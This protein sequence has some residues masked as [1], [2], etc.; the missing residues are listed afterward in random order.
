M[1]P[2][3][4]S[5]AKGGKHASKNH[6]QNKT[7]W[8][9]NPKTGHVAAMRELPIRGLC[10]KCRDILEW[11]KRMGKYKPLTVPKKCVGCG[12]KTVK[13][14]Y[15]VVCN[16][17][18]AEKRVC[19]KCQTS[20]DIVEIVESIPRSAARRTSESGPSLSPALTELLPFLPERHRRTVLR[21]LERG[22]W[23][24][25]EA[26]EK[27]G[28]LRRKGGDEDFDDLD[29]LDGFS[30][31]DGEGEEEGVGQGEGSDEEDGED[32]DFDSG[33]DED[34]DSGEDEEEGAGKVKGKGKLKPGR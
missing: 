28:K 24:D 33:E 22:D 29:D 20:T 16:K 8:L 18:A 4:V 32:E 15:H 13:D 14:A 6:H 25:E 31:E 21:K 2:E 17:C 19:A 5:S 10:G 27:A 34:F 26:V 11:R 9:H 1:P 30:S 12:N 3:K 23:T 7:A